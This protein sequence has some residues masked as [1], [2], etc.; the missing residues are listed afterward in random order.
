[1]FVYYSVLILFVPEFASTVVH[2]TR[3]PTGGY[4]EMAAEQTISLLLFFLAIPIV[5]DWI[6]SGAERRVGTLSTSSV[7]TPKTTSLNQQ[8][9][10]QSDQDEDG[11]VVKPMNQK[12]EE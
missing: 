9:Q 7:V 6:D 1:M 3:I 8:Q 11:N 12:K 2:R 10:Q 5:W 4:M